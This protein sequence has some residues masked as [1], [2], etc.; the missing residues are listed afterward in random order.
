MSLR[1]GVAILGV[2]EGGLEKRGAPP[3]CVGV[4]LGMGGD[5]LLIFDIFC[6]V[7][8]AG[9]SSSVRRWSLDLHRLEQG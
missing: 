3:L 6:A 1:Y 4:R 5:V 7:L 9:C 8:R 2:C